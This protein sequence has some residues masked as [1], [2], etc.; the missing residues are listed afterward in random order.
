M[1]VDKLQSNLS[2]DD[3]LSSDGSD[4]TVLDASGAETLVVPGGTMLLVA[5]FSREGPD[6]LIEGPNGEQVVV[7]DYFT[8]EDPP[9]LETSG[10]AQLTSD[11]VGRLAGSPM[12]N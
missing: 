12:G 1:A 2:A 9:A 4:A 10:G 6:L 7:R 8:L 5:D 3:L 11:L